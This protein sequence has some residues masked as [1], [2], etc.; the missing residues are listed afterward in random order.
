MSR[1]AQIYCV[2]LLSVFHVTPSALLT[3]NSAV[4]TVHAA[5]LWSSERDVVLMYV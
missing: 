5:L 2:H 3:V 4:S 1:V